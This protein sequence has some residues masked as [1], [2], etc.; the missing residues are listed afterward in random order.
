M[1]GGRILY[2]IY[3][4]IRYL[5]YSILSSNEPLFC[6]VLSSAKQGIF[7]GFSMEI[8]AYEISRLSVTG[9]K[10]MLKKKMNF[11]VLYIALRNR[12]L[13]LLW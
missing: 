5:L 6:L 3:D 2:R 4:R 1:E 13:C 9:L 10:G 11:V 8:V 7:Y 12:L